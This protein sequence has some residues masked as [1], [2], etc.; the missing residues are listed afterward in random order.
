MEQ[1]KTVRKS[2]DIELMV[3]SSHALP[4]AFKRYRRILRCAQGNCHQ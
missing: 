4:L 2:D 1:R 3:G